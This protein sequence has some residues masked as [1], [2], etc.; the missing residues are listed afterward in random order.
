M[1]SP[2]AHPSHGNAS[3]NLDIL[4]AYT[5]SIVNTVR[6]PLLVLD[7]ALRVTTASRAFYQAFAVPPA[8]TVNRFVYDLGNGQWNIPSLRNSLKK[9]FRSTRLST[10]SKSFTIFLASEER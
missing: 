5:D 10:T 1:S 8:E 7:S 3:A 6:E 9:C 4:L 2:G